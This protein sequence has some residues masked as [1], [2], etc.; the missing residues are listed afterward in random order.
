MHS[1]LF[2]DGDEDYAIH[3]APYRAAHLEYAR[4][5][6]AR[7]DLLLGGALA[8]PT[9]GA[10]LLFQGD[11]PAVAE[12]FA[13]NNPYVLNGVVKGWKVREW[14]TGVGKEAAHSLS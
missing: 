6:V 4:A 5:A 12:A 13:R 7:G 2:Y 8:N 10:L 3:R 1:L 14:T 11:S 9:D